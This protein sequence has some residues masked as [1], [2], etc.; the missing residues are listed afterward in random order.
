MV[1]ARSAPQAPPRKVLLVAGGLALA[2]GALSLVH[3]L[4]EPGGAATGGYG[5]EAAPHVDG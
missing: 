1:P 3:L 2:A 4:P 5:A